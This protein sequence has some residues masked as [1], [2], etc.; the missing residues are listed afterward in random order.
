MAAEVLLGST[1]RLIC[2]FNAQVSY[3]SDRVE[4]KTSCRFTKRLEV[5]YVLQR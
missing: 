2:T 1:T 3:I 5:V 4:T